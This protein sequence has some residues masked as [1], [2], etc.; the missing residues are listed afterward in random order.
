MLWALLARPDGAQLAVANLHASKAAPAATRDVE[1]AAR[2]AIAWS[3]DAPLV[4]GGDLNLFRARNPDVF[5]RLRNRYGFTPSAAEKVDH[6][7]ARGLEV[8]QEPCTLSPKWREVRSADGLA[9]RLSDHAP[10]VAS[11][12]TG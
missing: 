5:E 1:R 9:V 2:C 3:R 7:L 8:M 4:F 12:A 10:V 6:L 11:F